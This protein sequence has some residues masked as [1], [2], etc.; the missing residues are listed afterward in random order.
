M[1]KGSGMGKGL[2][3][4][5]G[6]GGAVYPM[7]GGQQAISSKIFVGGLRK[8]ETTQ[9]ALVQHFQQFGPVKGVEMKYDPTGAFR[10]FAFMA[11][12]SM[13]S[14][15]KVLDNYDNN[16]LLGKWIDCKPSEDVS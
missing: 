1:M 2:M 8:S 10:G 5:M 4:Q 6:K 3:G 13:E 11:F 15:Q 9:E 12:E 7:G 16:R 14:A